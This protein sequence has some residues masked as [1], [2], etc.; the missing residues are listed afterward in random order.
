MF[1]HVGMYR[2]KT[3][4][5]YILEVKNSPKVIPK[6]T[7]ELTLHSLRNRLKEIISFY[8]N[9]P[10]EEIRIS[11]K[12]ISFG[13]C[14]VFVYFFAPQNLNDQTKFILENYIQNIS[15]QLSIKKKFKEGNKII[16][17][18]LEIKETKILYSTS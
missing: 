15:K 8:E 4:T 5:N 3:K 14:C 7:K 10:K 2:Q 11:V 12:T 6:Q 1:Y 16:F 13:D 9:I 18:R 17:R